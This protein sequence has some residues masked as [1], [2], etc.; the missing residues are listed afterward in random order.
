MSTPIPIAAMTTATDISTTLRPSLV[1]GVLCGLGAGIVAGAVWFGI[2]VAIDRQIY[3]L[4]VALGLAIGYAVSWGAG[5]S[6]P[7]V[8]IVA[9]IMGLATVVISYYYVDRY[10]IVQAA[11]RE[12]YTT[13]L[14]L[15]P[16]LDQVK[17]VLRVSFDVEPM[18]YLFCALCTAGAAFF[19]YRGIDNTGFNRKR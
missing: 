5:R 13:T 7:A 11:E 19:G 18:Q 16:R 17:D 12:G 4:A 10:F 15:W 1:R 3:Y 9:G 14:S 6:G 8:A 2:V